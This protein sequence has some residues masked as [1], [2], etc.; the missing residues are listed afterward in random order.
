[1][2]PP[3]D[4][5][6]PGA[7]LGETKPFLYKDEWFAQDSTFLFGRAGIES[8]LVFSLTPYEAGVAF[9]LR[10]RPLQNPQL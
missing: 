3:K 7:V 1:M 4:W 9:V 6:P 10:P 2:D 8:L 5:V